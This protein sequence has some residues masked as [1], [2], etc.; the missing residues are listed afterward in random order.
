MDNVCNQL[1]CPYN[2]SKGCS[3]F[4]E[5]VWESFATKYCEEEVEEMLK[6][7]DGDKEDA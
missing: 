7:E 5:P 2:D 4:R 3:M 6:Y 1:D